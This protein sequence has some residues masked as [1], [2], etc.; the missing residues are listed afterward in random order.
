MLRMGNPNAAS[1]FRHLGPEPW[2]ARMGRAREMAGLTQEEA[3]ERVSLVVLSSG[4]AISRLEKMETVPPRAGKTRGV[5]RR[6]WCLVTL[7]G[8]DPAEFDLDPDDAPGVA[9]DLGI[10]ESGWI[11]DTPGTV[12]ALR[13]DLRR[14][15]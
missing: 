12:V 11:T 9:S 8:F 5:R 10:T 6:A 1:P 3:A 13:R 14:A 4:A 2:G 15:A 7:Y